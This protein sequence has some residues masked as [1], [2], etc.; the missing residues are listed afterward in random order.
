[1]K[2]PYKVGKFEAMTETIVPKTRQVIE[3]IHRMESRR[4]FATLI[5]LQ[6]CFDLAKADLHGAFAAAAEKWPQEG[7]PTP[8]VWLVSTGRFKRRLIPCAA[9]A[10]LMP[11]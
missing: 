10:G 9:A 4:V 7:G 11:L 1:M 5:L 2:P 3:A 8:Y 6:I